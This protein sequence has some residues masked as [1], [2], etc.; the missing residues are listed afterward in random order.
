MGEAGLND[1]LGKIRRAETPGYRRLRRLTLALLRPA[2]PRIPSWIKPAGRVCYH[3]HYFVI[4]SC[5]KLLGLFYYHPLFQSRCKSV[6]RNL[7]LE[8]LPYVAGPVEIFLGDDVSIGGNVTILSGRSFD[9]PRLAIGDRTVIGWYSTL[10]ASREVVIEEDVLIAP[11]CRISDTDG[12]PRDAVKRAQHVPP[13]PGEVK[14]VHIGRYA[15][16]GACSHVMKGVT[17]GEG[18]IIGANSVVVSDIPP[19]CIAMGNPAEVF[20]RNINKQS[21]ASG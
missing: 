9:R 11:S 20:F 3:G 13:A 4:S 1:F 7:S 5:R 8:G 16:I 6:G 19:Y 15:W 12:H 14:P 17:I 2:G 10:V 21:R 18:A